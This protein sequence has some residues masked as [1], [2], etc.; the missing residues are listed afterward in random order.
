MSD[1]LSRNLAKLGQGMYANT[2]YC[3]VRPAP[4][5]Y[6]YRE[7]VAL[8]TALVNDS[9]DVIDHVAERLDPKGRHNHP[10]H[11]GLFCLLHEVVPGAA[12]G[13]YRR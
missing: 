8:A 2:L 10:D 11:T 1:E 4:L 6:T 13:G 9:A 3:W 7:D 5:P 12:R